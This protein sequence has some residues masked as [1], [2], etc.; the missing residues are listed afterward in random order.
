VIAAQVLPLNNRIEVIKVI[1]PQNGLK[2]KLLG[3]LEVI[4]W[5]LIL[6]N[7]A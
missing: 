1:K 4:K 5:C 6:L 7:I 3:L 2:C